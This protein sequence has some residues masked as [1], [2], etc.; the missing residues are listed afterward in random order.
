MS[1]DDSYTNILLEEIRGQN[2][3]VVE[4]V[5]DLPTK[6]EVVAIKQD[7]KLVADDVKTI[8]AVVTDISQAVNNH[9]QRLTQLEA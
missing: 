5:R 8:K 9:Q 7:L 6:L 3:L 1:T 2:R 4:A